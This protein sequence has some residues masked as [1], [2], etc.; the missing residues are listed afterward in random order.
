MLN[1][2]IC[3]DEEVFINKIE[4]VITDYLKNKDIEFVIDSYVSS[5]KFAN[6]K[7]EMNKYDIVFMDINMAE[8]DGIAVSKVLRK[9]CPNTYLIFITAFINYTLEGYKVEAIR[10]ILKDYN[11]MEVDIAEA[12][13][14][15]LKK[16]DIE[17]TKIRYDF[18]GIG[19]RDI[20][21]NNIIYI[22][23][24]LHKLTLHLLIKGKRVSYELYK[25]ISDIEQDF[26][27]DYLVHTHQSFLVNI[28]YVTHIKRYEL[29]LSTGEL[30][31]ISKNRY[32]SV[33]EA[34]M[35]KKG[36]I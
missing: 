4:S 19:A 35:R 15:V 28:Q 11:N 29:T 10:Y 16:M 6:L 17:Y 23:N 36:E 8:L 34:F 30:I 24:D 26:Q 25:K 18:V 3:D 31:P 27:S 22:D 2:A 9:Y 32:K 7:N 14:T 1:I 5:L 13:E 21:V 20:S 33:Q 12:L